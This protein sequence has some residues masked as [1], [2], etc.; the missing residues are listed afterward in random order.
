MSE[1]M[2]CTKELSAYLN[3]HE[4]QIYALIRAGRIPATRLTGKWLFPPKVVDQWIEDSSKEGLAQ[5]KKKGERISGGLLASGSNDP[6]LDVLQTCL[7]K[8]HPEIL[9]LFI[10]CR[11]HGRT[12]G[13]QQGFYRR[14][15]L[16]APV[17]PETGEYNI[18]CLGKLAPHIKAVVVNLF[19]RKQGFLTDAGN[20][21]GI[22]E[23]EALARQVWWTHLSR[24]PEKA[25]I[26]S[27]FAFIAR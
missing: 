11:Q 21:L 22:K 6:V 3:I 12:G 27:S 2:M 15:S 10:Q 4:N 14:H 8:S 13:P 5:A 17:A 18:P 23:F 1:E 26:L 19:Y 20:P 16:V 9:Y 25:Q 24:A 7:K